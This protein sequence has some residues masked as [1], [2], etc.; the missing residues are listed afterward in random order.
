VHLKEQRKL[1]G[2][3]RIVHEVGDMRGG[4]GGQE[5]VDL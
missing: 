4:G 2:G 3:G 5:K 1:A